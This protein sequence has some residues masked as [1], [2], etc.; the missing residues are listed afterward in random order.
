VRD[1]IFPAYRRLRDFL[2]DEYLPHAREGVGLVHMRG[3]DIL[4]RRLI[5]ENTTLPL[6][7]DYVHNLGLSEVARIRGEMER[8]RT[9]SA[10]RAT[11]AQFFDHLRD[12]PRV[13]AAESRVDGASFIMTRARRVDAR[14]GRVLFKPCRA[15][16]P[17]NS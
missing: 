1:N 15:L 10:S 11:L 5:Q 4:Y 13:R 9:G 16:R 8:S 7:A 14:I 3:G 12:E 6:T 2:R 17:G